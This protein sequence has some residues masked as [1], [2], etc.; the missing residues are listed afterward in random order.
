[1]NNE[2][3]MWEPRRLMTLDQLREWV[4][5]AAPGQRCIYYRGH[6]LEEMGAGNQAKHPSMTTRH[7]LDVVAE[8]RAEGVLTTVQHRIGDGVYEYIAERT[9]PDRR[10]WP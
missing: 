8:L 3:L 10:R 1:M 7:L 6:I 4:G 2:G 9:V 5:S